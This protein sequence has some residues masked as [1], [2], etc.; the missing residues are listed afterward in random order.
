[1]LSRIDRL[2]KLAHIYELECLAS[3]EDAEYLKDAMKDCFQITFTPETWKDWVEANKNFIGD[4]LN[5]YW[6]V[7]YI[8]SNII[9]AEYTPKKYV[10]ISKSQDLNYENYIILEQA[11]LRAVSDIPNLWLSTF[12]FGHSELDKNTP[13]G[14]DIAHYGWVYKALGGMTVPD[15]GYLAGS[16]DIVEFIRGNKE[17]LDKLRQHFK[18]EPKML[19]KGADGSAF[20]IGGNNVLKIFNDKVSYEKAKEAI[21]RL[22]GN[23][24]L[25]RTEAMIYDVGEIGEIN[26]RTIYYYIMEKLKTMPSDST[27]RNRLSVLLGKIAFHINGEKKKEFLRRIKK[28]INDPSK[29]ER[30]KNIVKRVAEQI[31]TSL[32]YTDIGLIEYVADYITN[33]GT[34]LKPNWMNL[35]IE[36]IIM[37]YLTGRT[38]LHA[39]NIGITGNG[40]LRYFDPSFSGYT[41]W[42]NA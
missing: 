17:A 31:K 29:A 8:H 40:E 12:A 20:D 42:I 32:E 13:I 35:L 9:T 24:E 36:E 21:K 33:E 15:Y 27:F 38:D 30:I 10:M 34:E 19:G 23:P 5:L 37:K 22:H 2:V 18:G 28:Q 26:G 11:L 6:S 1:M 16:E 4:K 7:S 14:P 3:N 25:S 39:N 41:S